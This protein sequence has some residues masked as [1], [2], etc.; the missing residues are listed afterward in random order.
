MDDTYNIC[1]YGDADLSLRRC[2]DCDFATPYLDDGV[3]CG[4]SGAVLGL[5]AVRAFD[6]DD[7]GV[8]AEAIII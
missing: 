6:V 1:L 7:D 5:S 4:W 8:G 3:I 2:A